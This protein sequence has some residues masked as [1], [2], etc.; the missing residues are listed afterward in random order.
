MPANLPWN[1][2][3][4][5]RWS[6]WRTMAEVLRVRNWDRWQSY[7]S[8]RNQPPWIKIHRRLM[9]KP[10]WVELSDA[11]R[12]QLVCLWILAAEKGGVIPASPRL[13][14]KLCHLETEPDL[15][16]FIRL[17]FLEL[18]ANSASERRQ[19]GA[20]DKTRLDKTRL[21]ESLAREASDN[22]SDF[23]GEY[24]GCIAGMPDY[25]RRSIFGWY[26]PSGTRRDRFGAL[27]TERHAPI[28]ATAIL[29]WSATNPE[30][31][32]APF[33]H[34][35]VD[36]AIT[37]ALSNAPPGSEASQHTHES[38][39]EREAWRR[40]RAAHERWEK[41]EIERLNTGTA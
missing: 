16:V 13:L 9:S 7:R 26:G 39:E 10:K 38:E 17:R 37:A 19:D 40:A 32:Y 15:E 28:L 2:M 33:F 36:R 20:L 31:L 18:D 29:N 24:R 3:K 41:Q 8:D 22:L 6:A 1:L 23:L 34:K 30:N 14:K 21:E 12:G 27:E 11:Q 25:Q 5:V 35:I 4:V